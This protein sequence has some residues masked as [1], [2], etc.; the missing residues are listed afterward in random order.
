MPDPTERVARFVDALIR[1]RRPKRYAADKD[2]AGA[3]LAAASLRA[4]RPGSDLPSEQFVEDLRRRLAAETDKPG[5]GS[6][7]GWTRRRVLGM[8]TAAA[9][10]LLA[11]LGLDRLIN[12]E[13][14]NGPVAGRDISP[15]NA[16]WVGVVPLAAVAANQAVRFNAGAVEGFVI[17]R[18]GNISALSAVCTHMGCI[19]KFNANAHRLDCPCHGASFAL[20]GSPINRE[21]LNSLNHLSSRVRAGMV[22][23]QVDSTA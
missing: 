14:T 22:E 20:D 5:G 9:A 15:W 11:G 16:R 2:E 3:L 4:A 19:L 18:E 6:G 8:S 10:A 21:Y 12:R 7:G 1:D 17:N 23:V 13:E